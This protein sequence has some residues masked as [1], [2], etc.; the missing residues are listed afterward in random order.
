MRVRWEPASGQEGLLFPLCFRLFSKAKPELCTPVVHCVHLL[1]ERPQQHFASALSDHRILPPLPPVPATPAA[2]LGGS[3][4]NGST[5]EHNGE[6]HIAAGCLVTIHVTVQ[7]GPY[8]AHVEAEPSVGI[9]RGATLEFEESR[10][11]GEGVW[12]D[13]WRLQWRPSRDFLHRSYPACLL[14]RDELLA[15]SPP[16]STGPAILHPRQQVFCVWYRMALCR[17][18][19]EGGETLAGVAQ[20]WYGLDWLQLWG[21]NPEVLNPER[22][23]ANQE[24]RLGPLYAVKPGDT[25]ARL[26]RRFKLSLSSLRRFNPQVGS[27]ELLYEGQLLCVP[28]TVC[29][30]APNPDHPDPDP[31]P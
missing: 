1:V 23:G 19:A 5:V 22:V 12:Q 18:C 14:L 7:R 31:R 8:N 10:E 13:T 17:A 28:P 16:P 20:R 26:A 6:V 21:A 9:P 25:L 3:A 30:T 29:P 15:A 11:A 4:L 2:F 24:L 27:G